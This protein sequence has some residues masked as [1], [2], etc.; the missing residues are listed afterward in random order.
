V[1]GAEGVAGGDV[2]LPLGVGELVQQFE[3][4]QI[5]QLVEL[6]DDK[7]CVFHDVAPPKKV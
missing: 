1:D 4:F 3:Q 5:L 6:C 7:H 2:L